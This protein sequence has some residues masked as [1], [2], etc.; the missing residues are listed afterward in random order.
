M[1]LPSGDLVE[2]VHHNFRRLRAVFVSGVFFQRA[3]AI[4]ST[5]EERQKEIKHV[6]EALEAN[7]YRRWIF[8]LPKKKEKPNNDP[9]KKTTR[10]FTAPIGLPYVKGLLESLQRF[11]TH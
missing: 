11:F 1:N 9:S 8:N 2:I 7:G 4:S 10:P 6:K 5:P 3:E